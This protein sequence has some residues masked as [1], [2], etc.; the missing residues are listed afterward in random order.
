MG[1]W[2]GS[3]TSSTFLSRIRTTAARSQSVASAGVNQDGTLGFIH[4]RRIALLFDI[5]V[6]RRRAV[7][8]GRSGTRVGG[9][10]QDVNPLERPPGSSRTLDRVRL[11]SSLLDDTLRLR[12][13]IESLHRAFLHTATCASPA[14]E[15][16]ICCKVIQGPF[17]H[18]QTLLIGPPQ[19]WTLDMA[20]A[21]SPSESTTSLLLHQTSLSDLPASSSDAGPALP[22]LKVN[23]IVTGE[24]GT[25]LAS[26]SCRAE[27][28]ASLGPSLVSGCAST[29]GRA[30]CHELARQGANLALTDIS[31][32]GGQDLCME[33]QKAKYRGSL[34][35]SSFDPKDSERVGAFVRS[36]SKTLK[37]LDALVNCAMHSPEV[38]ARIIF[39]SCWLHTDPH[40]TGYSDASYQTSS[41]R[42]YA[43]PESESGLGSH[44]S[45]TGTLRE[46]E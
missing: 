7:E 42:R 25:G 24:R 17:T 40:L 5:F 34:L 37:R 28:Y 19:D 27:T 8:V 3:P 12:R 6:P 10:A 1:C 33:L 39:R 11:W 35:F 14:R 13:R 45:R 21:A 18:V 22:F 46:P 2:N 31:K 43:E 9:S 20:E 26:S 15:T 29:V 38:R 16:S 4:A 36:V 41:F 32:G 23:I 30:I 44:A